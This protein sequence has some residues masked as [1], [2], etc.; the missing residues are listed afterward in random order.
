MLL[1]QQRENREKKP[2]MNARQ[3]ALGA[4]G[5]LALGSLLIFAA[6]QATRGQT[7]PAAQPPPA[8]IERA[9]AQVSVDSGV[10]ATAIKLVSAEA[11]E[12]PDAG[13]GCPAPGMTY[14][15]VVTPGYRL[16]FQA[17]DTRYE[18][19]TGTDAGSRVA[20]CGQV[21]PR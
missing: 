4:L 7:P 13:L 17:G 16:V 3:W 19:H 5:V 1:D 8:L 9:T 14:A 10:A 6:G 21:T 2:N 18:I 20:P 15:Q 11:V 12:W